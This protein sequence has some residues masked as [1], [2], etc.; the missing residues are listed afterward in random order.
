M[1][2][3]S[4]SKHLETLRSRLFRAFETHQEPSRVNIK[5]IAY[6]QSKQQTE[7]L[8]FTDIR[9]LKRSFRNST[10]STALKSL[11]A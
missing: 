10:E 1:T 4:K 7:E 3:R 5:F 11:N 6:R 2:Q 9:W 8:K